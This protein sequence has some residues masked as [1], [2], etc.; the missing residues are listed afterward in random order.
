MLPGREARAISGISM[1]GFGALRFA[2]AYPE[3]FSAVGAQSAALILETPEQLNTMAQE[4]SSPRQLTSCSTSWEIRSTLPT[5]RRMIHSCSPGKTIGRT[6]E[7]GD[8]PQLRADRRLW[9]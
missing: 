8:L 4:R 3:L 7:D 6:E 9:L 2:F 5:G 1:G